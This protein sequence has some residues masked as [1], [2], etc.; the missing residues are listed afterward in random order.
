MSAE[1]APLLYS[2]WVAYTAN[3]GE[4]RYLGQNG[5]PINLTEAEDVIGLKKGLRRD[6]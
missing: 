5:I 3:G 4:R 6:I 2:A 1:A